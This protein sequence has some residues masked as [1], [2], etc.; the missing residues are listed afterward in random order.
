MAIG[1]CSTHLQASEQSGQT[2]KW[3]FTSGQGRTGAS[4][5]GRQAPAC[6]ALPR[7]QRCWTW[8]VVPRRGPRH[9][10]LPRLGGS[11]PSMRVDLGEL[12]L[13]AGQRA[14]L[15]VVQKEPGALGALQA[16]KMGRGFRAQPTYDTGPFQANTANES[17]EVT[18]WQRHVRQNEQGHVAL[19]H[20]VYGSNA[21]HSCAQFPSCQRFGTRPNRSCKI[22]VCRCS[23]TRGKTCSSVA[24]GGSGWRLAA[25]LC[26]L[27][28]PIPAILNGPALI[29]A[30]ERR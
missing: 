1:S 21:V 29:S 15:R 26:A 16:G 28:G 30:P 11:S 2:Q 7:V 5:C 3:G 23:R 24:G 8:H 13:S 4:A 25:L 6:T 18:S 12:D 22:R 14:A 27:T 19:A 10:L 9:V 20:L 17:G